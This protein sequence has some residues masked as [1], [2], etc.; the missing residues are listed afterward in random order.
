MKIILMHSKWYFTLAYSYMYIAL[1]GDT[2]KKENLSLWSLRDITT[3][4][5]RNQDLKAKN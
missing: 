3:Y 4:I 2:E 1:R 5:D